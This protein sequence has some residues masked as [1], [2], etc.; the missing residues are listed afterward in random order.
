MKVYDKSV[1]KVNAGTVDG[2]VVLDTEGPLSPVAKPIIKRI[3]RIFQEERPISSDE[4]NIIFSTWVP[5]MPS[6]AFNRMIS[7]QVASILKKRVPDQLSI[8]ITGKCPYD[9]IHCGAA[10]IVTDPELSFDE[11]NSTI[12]QALDLGSYYVSFD[13]G[14]TMLRKDLPEM[15]E[16]VDKNRAIATCF[17]SG[18]ALDEERAG[19]LKDAGLFAV[20][21]SLDSPDEKEHDKVRGREGAFGKMVS[22]ARHAL[23]AGILA[24]LFVVISPYNIDDLDG[25]YQ[26]AC[27]MGMHEMT[28]YEIVAVGRWL[29]HEDE[30]ISNKDVKRLEDFQKTINRKAE[31]PRVTAL[32]YFMGPDQFGC[33]A[34]KRWMHTTAGGDVLPCAYTPLSFGNVREE[35]LS[36]IWERMGRHEA[37]KCS[38]D[39]CMMRNPDF[40]KKYIHTIPQGEQLPFRVENLTTL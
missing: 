20:H 28:V 26:F 24:D 35:K 12:E 14:E 3:N 33:F 29:E 6:E 13:G 25:F 4:E 32:P 10:G 2:K 27:D 16:R 21:M 40:R 39:Y 1:L 9:C 15:V 38:A 18:F 8:G 37:Y 7:S 5:P 23:D 11:I 17:T 22:G 36:T 34:G 31:G 19:K 30:V